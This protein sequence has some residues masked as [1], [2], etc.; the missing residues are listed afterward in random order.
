[1]I[2]NRP[3]GFITRESAERAIKPKYHHEIKWIKKKN[4]E[5]N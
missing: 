5:S 3:F 1:M 2:M 4:T